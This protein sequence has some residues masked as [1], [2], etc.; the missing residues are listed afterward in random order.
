MKFYTIV[1][2][3]AHPE[4]P[5]HRGHGGALL[6]NQPAQNRRFSRTFLFLQERER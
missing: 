4:D 6:R 5:C 2:P 3:Q 1:G